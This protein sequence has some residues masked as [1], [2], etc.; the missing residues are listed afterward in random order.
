MAR[1]L[2]G[3][4]P[5]GVWLVELAGLSEGKLVPQA[6]AAAL[7]VKERPS[8]PLTVTLGEFLRAKWMLLVVDNCEHL[9]EG[10]AGL[11]DIVLDSCPHL[12]IL[13][14][15]RS[16]L[17]VTGEQLIS[18]IERNGV[19]FVHADNTDLEK[20]LSSGRRVENDPA[21]SRWKA[22]SSPV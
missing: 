10:T 7:R 9:L 13:A 2:A 17:G 4:Y 1:D 14:T 5:D 6:V 3:A 8:Q 11:V 19:G 15:S 22:S 21:S 12:R 18:L 16:P 20:E